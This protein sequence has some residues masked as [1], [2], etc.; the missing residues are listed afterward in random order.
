MRQAA[1]KSSLWSE[2]GQGTKLVVAYVGSLVEG[3][4]RGRDH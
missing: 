1:R 3:E 2:N 4:Q